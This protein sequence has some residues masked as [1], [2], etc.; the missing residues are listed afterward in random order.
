MKQFITDILEDKLI[1]IQILILQKSSSDLNHNFTFS[2]YNY[3]KLFL[4]DRRIKTYIFNG[5]DW[6]ISFLEL[7]KLI[8]GKYFIIFNKLIKL[9][10]SDLYKIYNITK[11]NIE[12]ILDLKFQNNRTFYLIRTKILRDILDSNKN[13]RS[14]N[15]LIK[16]LNEKSIPNINYIP[17]AY[18]PD[19][20]YVSLTYNSMLSVLISKS[21]Y[22]FILFYLVIPLDFKQ[23]G[24]RIFE[25]LYE[26]F[27][28]FNITFIKMDNR[29]EKAYTNRYLTKNAF[30]RLSLG[31]LLPDL[32][33]IIYLD[34]DTICLKDLSNLYN[35]NFMGKIFLGKIISF[36]SESHNFDLNTGVLLL[37]LIE[38]RNL[39]IEKKVLTLLNKGF[40]DP[41]YHDQA[42]LNI[43][44]KK[45]IGFLPLE[46]NVFPY[47]NKQIENLTKNYN[48]LYDY[49]SLYFSNKYPSI[50]HFPGI[51]ENKIYFQEDWYY[52]ARK[53]KYFQKASHNFSDIFNH[54]LF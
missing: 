4:N 5:A 54:N 51:P 15:E 2:S 13:F 21:H 6:E 42:I 45:Y 30:Y 19:N 36:E 41:V 12:N 47:S 17:I 23:S 26:Q 53:S 33:K 14:F 7:I 34:A 3:S 40:R 38:M 44:F 1:D 49:D 39:K 37:N 48:N 16:H 20:F 25:S 52:F 22:T 27:E 46:Y 43:F 35:I 24:I 31:E 18:C 32:N 29:F 9:Q 8:K 11:G 10:K 28:Y 50:K